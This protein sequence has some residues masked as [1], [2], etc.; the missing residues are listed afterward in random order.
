MTVAI[1]SQPQCVSWLDCKFVIVANSF[2]GYHVSSF[3]YYFF[4]YIYN[5]NL[6]CLICHLPNRFFKIIKVPC[7]SIS[8]DKWREHV[9]TDALVNRQ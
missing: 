1:L 5:T 9:I 6:F 8:Q 7:T 3:S 4:I 2:S